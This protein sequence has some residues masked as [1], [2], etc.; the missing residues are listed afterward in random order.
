MRRFLMF[1]AAVWLC[2]A[3]ANAQTQVGGTAQFA[4]PDPV[5]M[6]PVG[7][8][9]NHSLVVEQLKCTW[10][11]PMEIGGDKSKD[12]ISTE[13]A[14]VSGNTGRAHGFHVGTMESG[15]KFFVWYQGISTL[16]EGNPTELKGNWGFNGGTGKLK[17]LKGKGT[18]NCTPAGDG[19]A[20]DIEG[21]YQLGK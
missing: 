17:S 20:C 12:G 16:K 21:E 6:L 11:K 18:Y 7:D 9:P 5:H 10:T 4:K 15:D 14:D 2:A 13:T 8:R 19:L 1:A 3:T